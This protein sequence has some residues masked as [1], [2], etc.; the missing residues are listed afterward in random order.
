M[1]LNEY[2]EYEAKKE[3]RIRRNVRSKINL[4]KYEGADFNY[5]NRDKSRAFDYLYYHEDIEIKKYYELPILLSCFQPTQPYTELGLVS[6]SESNEVD[7]DSMI[8]EEYEL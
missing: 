5:F 4:T 2:L 7:I 8:T 3:R 6:S 1:T